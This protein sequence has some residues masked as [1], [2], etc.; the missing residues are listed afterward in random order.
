MGGRH[1]T[2]VELS[3]LKKL[4]SKGYADYQIAERMN[5]SRESVSQQRRRLGIS[6]AS[7]KNTPAAKRR[8]RSVRGHIVG[9][10]AFVSRCRAIK[11]GV[12]GAPG[13]KSALVLK[14]LAS[15][16]KT[17]RE[18]SSVC[19]PEMLWRLKKQGLVEVGYKTVK[20]VGGGVRSAV[21]RL[22]SS[23]KVR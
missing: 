5:R 23:V 14:A 17:T 15:G 8:V 22:S 12:P 10:W 3:R 20:R 6:G 2:K 4:K 16:Q 1:W 11:L 7:Q 21:W 13:P 9:L 18:L 19:G